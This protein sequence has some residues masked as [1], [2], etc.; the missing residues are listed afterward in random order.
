MIT[1]DQDTRSLRRELERA[2]FGRRCSVSVSV[3]RQ[4]LKDVTSRTITAWAILPLNRS[5]CEGDLA[6]Y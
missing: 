3:A 1:G 4:V 5:G 2:M 6:S